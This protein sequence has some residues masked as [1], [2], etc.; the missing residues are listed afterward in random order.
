VGAPARELL[1]TPHGFTALHLATHGVIDPDV[2]ERSHLVLGPSDTLAYGEIPGLSEG[3]ADCRLVVLSACESALPVDGDLGGQG[4]VTS[5]NGLAAQFRRAGVET[6]LA[7]LW[8]VDDQATGRLM[9]RFYAELA[10]GADLATALRRA[11]ASVRE[12]PGWEHPWFWAGFVL[13]GDWR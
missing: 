13:V 12:T 6:L 3:L 10:A 5:I 9:D 8:K 2:P 11:Q 7:S 1:A 4:V